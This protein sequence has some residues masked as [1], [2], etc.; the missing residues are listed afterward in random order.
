MLVQVNDLLSNLIGISNYAVLVILESKH[1]F[2]SPGEDNLRELRRG[3]LGR[4]AT[5]MYCAFTQMVYVSANT[6][7]V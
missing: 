1:R 2:L 4:E 6:T 7:Q 3:K 5:Y